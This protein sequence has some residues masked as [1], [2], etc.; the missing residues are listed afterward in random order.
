M[1]LRTAVRTSVGAALLGLL[2]VAPP[3][4][5]EWGSWIA[6]LGTGFEYRTNLNNSAFSGD[7][8]DDGAW[9]ASGRG[10]RIYQASDST[11]ISLALDFASAVQFEFDGLNRVRGSGEVAVM[12]KFGIG[13][14]VP[15]LRVF[16]KAGYLAVDDHDRSGGVYE[17]G[18]S[19]SKRISERF[20]GDIFFKYHNYDGGNGDVVLATLPTNVWDQENFEVGVNTS[21]LAWEGLL[22]TA[23][24][25]YRNG[26]FNSQCTTGNVA[27]VFAR[28]GSNVKAI[29]RDNV[30][31]GCVYRLGGDVHQFQ[32]G[33]N[34]AITDHFAADLG[35]KYQYAKADELIYRNHVV[36]LSLLYSY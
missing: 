8:E 15:M 29:A 13:P 22:A 18:F 21:Y 9:T 12:H 23:G 2:A 14:K 20:D 24:Y 34:Y 19:V 11:R 31:G 26:E 33:L 1:G 6:E 36:S 7:I 27:T 25:A 32:G 28:E 5:A 17:T 3:A 4:A 16:G 35:Y 30:F 10:G